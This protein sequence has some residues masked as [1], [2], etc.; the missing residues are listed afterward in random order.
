MTR[1]CDLQDLIAGVTQAAK[2]AQAD[3]EPRWGLDPDSQ[4][5]TG[6]P[7]L[8]PA[9]DPAFEPCFLC[10]EGVTTPGSAGLEHPGLPT[11]VHSLGSPAAEQ[12]LMVVDG[13]VLAYLSVSIDPC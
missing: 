10:E 11:L 3:P 8:P 9:Q 7:A 5:R 1:L 2:A 4:P 12:Q 13:G 6:A